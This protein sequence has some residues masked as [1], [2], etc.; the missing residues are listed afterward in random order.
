MGFLIVIGVIVILVVITVQSGI[1]KESKIMKDKKKKKENFIKE[2]GIPQDAIQIQ[3]I[4]H[5]EDSIYRNMYI[6]L[7]NNLNLQTVE[8]QSSQHIKERIIISI[9]DVIYY[10]RYG[11]HREETKVVGEKPNIKKAI[12][13]GVIAGPAGAIIGAMDKKVITETEKIDKR[14]TYLYYTKDDIKNTFV[15]DSKAFNA[16]YK[17]IP[18]KAKN[19]VM[20]I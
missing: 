6:W 11:E 9:D 14:N 16:F 5:N 19:I 12:V 15:F 3:C 4:K 2:N 18:K 20:D 17:T 13:G 8:G 10:E 1:K 7:D